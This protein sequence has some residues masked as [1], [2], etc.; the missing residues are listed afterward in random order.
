VAKYNPFSFFLVNCFW[1]HFSPFRKAIF[2]TQKQFAKKMAPIAGKYFF[3]NI[4]VFVSLSK[5]AG[6]LDF[7][8][9]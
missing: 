3:Q 8:K 6:T 5:Y 1:E 7:P 9:K 2:R 4:L